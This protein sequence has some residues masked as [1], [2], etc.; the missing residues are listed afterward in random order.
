MQDTSQVNPACDLRAIREAVCVHTDK[1]TDSCLAKDCIEDL[2]VYLTVDS[3]NTLDCATSARARFVELLHV[4]VQVEPVPFSSGN[5]TVDVTFYYRIIADASVSTGRPV[6]ITGL[7]VFS[8]RLVLFGGETSAKVF[9]SR[10]SVSCLCKEAIQA[11]SLPQAVVEVV[12]PIIL[13]SRVQDACSC[14]CCCQPNTPQIPD[15][16]LECF[17]GDLVLS[18]EC[19]SLLVTIGQFSITR[20]ERDTQL[21]LP[22]FDYCVPNKECP[23]ASNAA[24]QN[25]CE[26][27]SQIDFPIDAF[28]PTKGQT[29]IPPSQSC[30]GCSRTE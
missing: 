6:T 13:G 27:F 22:V 1:I 14:S 24:A 19:K 16:I 28:F 2:H 15:A 26:I 25:P 17:E 20:L 21:L 10:T 3:Q 5:F 30:T 23:N 11:A 9:S 18:G 4:A 8:K 7:G 12:E 29:C